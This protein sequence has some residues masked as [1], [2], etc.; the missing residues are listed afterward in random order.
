MQTINW[1]DLYN[2]KLTS[3]FIPKIG[4]NFDKQYCDGQEVLGDETIERYQDY[5]QDSEYINLFNNYTFISNNRWNKPSSN[6][7]NNNSNPN[8]TN[9]IQVESTTQ[10]S[11]PSS[12]IKISK[13]PFPRPLCNQYSTSSIFKQGSRL[14]SH[15]LITPKDITKQLQ[16]SKMDLFLGKSMSMKIIP[17]ANVKGMKINCNNDISNITERKNSHKAIANKAFVNNFLTQQK[18]S[19]R[20][21]HPFPLSSNTSRPNSPHESDDRSIVNSYTK[22]I[23]ALKTIDVEKNLPLIS[24]IQ[25]KFKNTNCLFSPTSMKNIKD[26][27]SLSITK[28]NFNQQKIKP[29]I[30]FASI[31]ISARKKFIGLHNKTNS[32]SILEKLYKK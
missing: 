18:F 5:I 4:D 8:N 25:R 13:N 23:K 10:V 28:S 22:K 9:N 15:N 29:K 32:A 14:P 17:Q 3:P 30:K 1:K 11:T 6:C 27:H 24:F 26:E 16:Q 19:K 20:L 7:N 2:H 31:N 21:L 12:L